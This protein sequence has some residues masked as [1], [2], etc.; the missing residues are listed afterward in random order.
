MKKATKEA[1]PANESGRITSVVNLNFK[2]ACDKCGHAW[3]WTSC[4]ISFWKKLGELEWGWQVQPDCEPG[5][6]PF[7]P[8][9]SLNFKA[10]IE[11]AQ[12]GL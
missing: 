1:R 6:D 5:Q 7:I 10:Q 8:R 4:V 2:G 9:L 3:V 11:Q 12:G